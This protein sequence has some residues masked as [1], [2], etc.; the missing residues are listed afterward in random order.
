MS[1]I[2]NFSAGPSTLPES[3]LLKAKEELL[4]WR[5]TGMSVMEISHR[6]KEFMSLA[7]ELKSDLIELLG[8]PDNYKILFLQ[9]GATGQFAS[10]PQNILRGNNKACYVNTGAWSTKA[11]K[12][13]QNHCDVIVSA[14]SK[15]SNFTDILDYAD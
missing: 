10:I 6:G 9:G 4:D 14:D 11:I 8:V 7:E 15:A 2:F 1:R 13:A 5:G 3:V 12:E